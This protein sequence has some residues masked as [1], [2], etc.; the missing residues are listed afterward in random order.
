MEKNHFTLE[1][2]ALR[3]MANYYKLTI[4]RLLAVIE[5]K[6]DDCGIEPEDAGYSVNNFTQDDKYK[7]LSLAVF[8]LPKG[9]SKVAEMLGRCKIMF[10]D[11]QIP[12]P[13]C[14]AEGED[15]FEGFIDLEDSVE[16]RWRATCSNC[17]KEFTFTP[18][19]D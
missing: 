5:S 3:E 9:S 11:S 16:A 1:G 8:L 12:C 17:G 15:L 13:D 18:E 14:G 10:R 4:S 6:I 7:L 19:N 2:E